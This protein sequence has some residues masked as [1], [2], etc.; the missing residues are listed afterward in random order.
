MEALSMIFDADTVYAI[1]EAF[2]DQ[3]ITV[4]GYA[5]HICSHSGKRCF[6]T[7]EGQKYSI[8][9]EAEGD[10]G[11]FDQEQV[12]TLL[13]V[14]GVLRER[15]LTG[16]EIADMEKD[17]AMRMEDEE[18]DEES[19]ETCENELANIHEMREWMEERGKDYYSIY[20]IDGLKYH[21]ASH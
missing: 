20:Y 12:G 16:T 19:L 18:A 17:V 10:I 9:V 1:A 4:K 2:I 21:D 3:P 8:R 14:E 11:R 15:R 7:G 13:T 6:L 5:T